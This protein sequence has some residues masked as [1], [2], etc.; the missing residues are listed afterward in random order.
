MP[1]NGHELSKEFPIGKAQDNMMRNPS[2]TSTNRETTRYL[3][4]ATQI[5]THYA[6]NVVNRIFGEPLK[7]LAPSYGIDIVT[8]AKWAIKA[9]HTQSIRDVILAF[10][11]TLQACFI[12]LSAINS[13][14]FLIAIPGL[15]TVAWINVSWEYWERRHNRIIRQLLRDRFIPSE[16]PSPKHPD[17]QKRLQEIDERKDGNLVVFSGHFAFVGT[18]SSVHQQRMLFD[19]RPKEEPE[20]ESDPESDPDSKP[21]PE[22]G[23]E[24]PPAEAEYFSSHD[25][26]TAIVQAFDDARGLGKSLNNIRVYERLFVNGIHIQGG[27]ELL[28]NPLQPPPTL[29]ENDLLTA[30]SINPS[31]DARSYVCVEMLGWQ[32]QLV[33][34]LFARAVYTGRSLF[35][36]WT[37]RVLPPL[38]TAFLKIDELYELPPYQQLLNSLSVGIR[39]TTAALLCSP[40]A[41]LRLTLRPRMA[42]IQRSRLKYAI[43][44]GYVYDYGARR[45]IREYA[46]GNQR[47]HYFLARDESMYVLLA[48]QTLIQAVRDFLGEHGVDLGQFDNQA[49]V[50]FDQSIHIGDIKDSTGIA[51]GNDSSANVNKPSGGKSE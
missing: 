32:G 3:A 12:I 43:S 44:H 9:L 45:S 24:K 19:I 2:L 46:S 39:K 4:A 27:E 28:P 26:H 22:Q 6:A 34:T 42:R 51:I 21:E 14:W 18:G 15:F 50:I 36:E 23:R 29:V 1:V 11:L 35:V 13:P 8:V 20:S 40:V 49:Q 38:R 31:P 48:Q 7:A 25:I 16:A 33:V 47:G 5:D 17:Q 37:F 30:A 10:I 41:A